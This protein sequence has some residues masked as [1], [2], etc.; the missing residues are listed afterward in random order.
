MVEAIRSNHIA[1]ECTVISP[2]AGGVERARAFAKRLGSDL[3]IID[4]RRSKPNESEVMRVIG[5][6]VSRDVV[7]LD[8]MVD[9]A[10]TLVKSADALEA[11]GARNVYACCSHPVLSGDAVEKINNSCIQRLYVTDTIPAGDKLAKCPKLQVHSVAPLLGE[12]I[13]RIH[14]EDSLSAL[15][16]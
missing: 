11:A 1:H 4:K 14:R 13:S 10:G 2:D 8:D 12:A 6:V 16:V 3:A 9:T 5:D 7:I 15:F